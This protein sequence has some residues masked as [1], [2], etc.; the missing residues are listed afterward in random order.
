MDAATTATLI[1]I[2]GVLSLLFGHHLR[3]LAL[4]FWDV[5]FPRRYGGGSSSPLSPPDKISS[6]SEDSLSPEDRERLVR[7]SNLTRREA[8]ERRRFWMQAF[9]TVIVLVAAIYVLVFKP[10]A[11]TS[12]KDFCYTS[13]GAIIG[14]WLKG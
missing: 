13:V 7:A 8:A 6:H 14:F 2:L 5:L 4:I 1:A 9:V 10:D 3:N 12:L 11:E